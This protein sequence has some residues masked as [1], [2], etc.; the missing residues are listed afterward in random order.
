LPAGHRD[1]CWIALLRGINVGTAKRVAMADLR[2]LVEGLGFSDV[3]TLLN[4][5][6]VVFHAPAGSMASPA[7]A[8]ERALAERLGVSSA[9]IAI[10]AP[11]LDAM[12]KENPLAKPSRDPS[13]LLVA[14]IRDKAARARLEPLLEQKWGDEELVCGKHAAYIWCPQGISAGK[15][16]TA[17]NKALGDGVTMRNLTTIQKLQA[18]TRGR[19]ATTDDR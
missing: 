10:T 18:M 5:G 15:L 12:L 13:R 17:M 14:A 2:S 9:V 8:I 4:S 1:A 19:S 6:N 7:A 11:T 3:A 16:F